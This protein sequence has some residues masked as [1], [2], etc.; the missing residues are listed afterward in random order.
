MLRLISGFVISSLL[1]LKFVGEMLVILCGL[2]GLYWFFVNGELFKLEIGVEGR[3]YL[4][5]CWLESVWVSLS[6]RGVWEWKYFWIE[7][8]LLVF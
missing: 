8:Y 3:F 4:N 6:D 1:L 5:W 2:V 7:E